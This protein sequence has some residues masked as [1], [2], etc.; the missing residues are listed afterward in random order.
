MMVLI[1]SEKLTD[2]PLVVAGIH[3][4]AIVDGAVISGCGSRRSFTGGYSRR[5]LMAICQF[6]GRREGIYAHRRWAVGRA[7]YCL[8]PSG[9]A[10]VA[11]R[12]AVLVWLIGV[13]PLVPLIILLLV[14][15]VFCPPMTLYAL[16]SG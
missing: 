12:P 2:D 6:L 16:C 9:V 13:V 11:V 14:V 7:R 3:T 10:P 8:V 4:A 1:A 15:G 5:L